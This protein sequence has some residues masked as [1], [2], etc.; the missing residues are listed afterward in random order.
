M[1]RQEQIQVLTEYKTRLLTENNKYHGVNQMAIHSDKAVMCCC[2]CF[3]H[4]SKLDVIIHFWVPYRFIY[5]NCKDGYS[6]KTFSWLIIKAIEK[7]IEN[8]EARK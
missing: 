6:K 1:T 4:G 3:S 8:L 5:N 2:A 7:E